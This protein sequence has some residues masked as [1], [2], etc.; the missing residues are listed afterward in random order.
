MNCARMRA[1][2][3]ATF[4][5]CAGVLPII[6]GSTYSEYC[7]FLEEQYANLDPVVRRRAR[8]EGRQRLREQGV[9]S[10]AIRLIPVP[11][12][13]FDASTIQSE[14][15]RNRRAKYQDQ[16]RRWPPETPPCPKCRIARGMPKRS[17]PTREM[18]EIVR[19]QQNDPNLRVYP[20]PAQPG[21]WHLG[22]RRNR[23]R[24]SSSATQPKSTTSTKNLD[25]V[26]QSG[27]KA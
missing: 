10:A 13:V 22:H 6:Q 3:I 8:V 9:K 25:P 11:S 19:S 15:R 12:P 14:L 5:E 24:T 26:D 1:A 20:C 27:A 7:K 4:I 16:I 2:R 23:H 21:L 17:W 18:A